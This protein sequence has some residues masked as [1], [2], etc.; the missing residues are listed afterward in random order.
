MTTTL[1]FAVGM[2]TLL[3]P[4]LIPLPL[5]NVRVVNTPLPYSTVVSNPSKLIVA[6]LPIPDTLATAT[7]LAVFAKLA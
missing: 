4:L 6:M 3:A 5:G 2:V 1:P 7:L